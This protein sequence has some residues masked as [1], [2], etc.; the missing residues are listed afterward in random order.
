MS[1]SLKEAQGSVDEWISQFEE[2]YWSPLSMLARL[3]EE[4][5]ELSRE[6]NAQYGEKPKKEEEE[7]KLESEM[8]DVLFTLICMANSL[9]IDLG[10]SLAKVMEKYNIRDAER[11]KKRES[12]F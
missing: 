4:V 11:W 8:G 2:G 6:M 9:G 3:T 7:D 5:G 12:K 10:E 1:I